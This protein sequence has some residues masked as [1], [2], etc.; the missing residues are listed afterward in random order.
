MNTLGYMIRWRGACS[1]QP[2]AATPIGKFCDPRI[3]DAPFLRASTQPFDVSGD[4]LGVQLGDLAG[5][6]ELYIYNIKTASVLQTLPMPSTSTVITWCDNTL[7]AADKHSMIMMLNDLD[8]RGACRTCRASRWRRRPGMTW[9]PEN[10]AVYT[11]PSASSAFTLSRSANSIGSAR[12]YQIA[13]GYAKVR[14][15]RLEDERQAVV[16]VLL[17]QAG[18]VPEHRRRRC[19]G[20]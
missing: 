12:E 14:G 8:D 15:Q 6:R 7:Y 17:G 20:R 13:V 9:S 10:L 18:L 19:D 2:K 5:K 16:H 3:L 11:L 4:L 1:V